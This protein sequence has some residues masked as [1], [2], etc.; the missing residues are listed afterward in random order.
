MRT[1]V[2]RRQVETCP[3][4][5]AWDPFRKGRCGL[6]TVDRTTGLKRIY[7]RC[8]NCGKKLVLQYVAGGILDENRAEYPQ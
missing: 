7:G 1:P 3:Y 8:R 4:C 6:T 2:I 5:G